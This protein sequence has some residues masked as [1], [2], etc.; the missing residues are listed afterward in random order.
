MNAGVLAENVRDTKRFCVARRLAGGPPRGAR[1]ANASHV[2]PSD[3]RGM[4]GLLYLAK[5]TARGAGLDKFS[6]AQ[7]IST[8]LMLSCFANRH[9]RDRLD[10]PFEVRLTNRHDFSIRRRI[11]KVD[12]HRNAIADGEL[13]RVQV[14]AEVLIQLQDAALDILQYFLWGLPL[15]LIS[16]M[17]RMLWIVRHDADIALID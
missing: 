14:V 17:I 2:I 11:T 8:G 16:Q 15:G 12:R 6:P 10:H 7:I 13:D 5:R 9:L 1:N 4:T 3:S